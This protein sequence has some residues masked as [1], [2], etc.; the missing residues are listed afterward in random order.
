MIVGICS[1]IRGSYKL[2]GGADVPADPDPYFAAIGLGQ[3]GDV[4]D[5]G[6]QQPFAV[7][8]AGGRR[9]PQGGQVSGEFLQ[10]APAGQRRQRV[11][12]GLERLPGLS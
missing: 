10:V 7:P 2:V 9:V 4:G 8:G 3:H 12:G 1:L 5:Q 6:A 11:L